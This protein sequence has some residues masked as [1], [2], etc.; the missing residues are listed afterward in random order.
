MVRRGRNSNHQTF[1][2]ECKQRRNKTNK[3]GIKKE[4]YQTKK[5]YKQWMSLNKRGIYTNEEYKE[6]RNK[7]KG[8]P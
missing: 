7:N 5:K 3:G 8:G 1:S 6:R 2:E 4:E